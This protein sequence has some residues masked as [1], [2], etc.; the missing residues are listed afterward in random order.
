[1]QPALQVGAMFEAGLVPA[2]ID[3]V[4]AQPGAL[5]LLQYA[6]TELFERRQERLLTLAAYKEIGGVLGA[7]GRRAEELYADLDAAGQE[8]A[9]QVF[10]RLVTLGEGTEDTRRRV[11]RSELMA[12][13]TSEVSETS[14]VLD[15]YGRYRLLT[16][17]HDPVSREPT[18]EVAHEA[19]LRE[20]ER[21]RDWLDESRDDVRLQRSLALFAAEWADN[22]QAEGFLLRDSRLDLFTGWAAG[23]NLALTAA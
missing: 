13:Q 19:L 5:P 11:L 7:L 12:L 4:G 1:M 2:I 8:A 14:E 10:M 21:L 6:L 15:A 23:T 16:F 3:E 22:N 18:V 17:D 9:R 20:W